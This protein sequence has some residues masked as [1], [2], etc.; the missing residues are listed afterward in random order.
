[1]CVYNQDMEANVFSP[2]VSSL[3]SGKPVHEC[4]APVRE[5]GYNHYEFWSWWDQDVDKIL[6]EQTRLAMK[7]AAMC[8]RFIPLNDP[9]RRSEYLQGLRESL[10]VAGLLGC[11]V[12]I[13]QAGQALEGVTRAR[14]HDS[15][16][17][18][19]TAC[20][21]LLKGTGVTL[22][23]EPLNIQIDHPGYYLT[24][25]TEAFDIAGEVGSG[26]VK[27]LYD[28]YHQYITERSPLSD[29]LDNL[30]AIAHFHLAGYPGRHEPW[31]DSEIDYRAIL[32]AIRSAGYEGGIGLEYSPLGDVGEGLREFAE[33]R[34]MGD[35][36]ETSQLS[37]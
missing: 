6:D 27:V 15:I 34:V 32:R 16:R 30:N 28:I 25:A 14:Q 19:L 3:F 26:S 31:V 11:P 9:A 17:D 22:A 2:C 12:I 37:S 1:M 33:L 23:L 24:H 36:T 7:P 10:R 35:I 13:S 20:L 8:T 29:I 21:P 18:G 4:L 5:A